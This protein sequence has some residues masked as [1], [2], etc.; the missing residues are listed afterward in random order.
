MKSQI[1]EVKW[2]SSKILNKTYNIDTPYWICYKAKQKTLKQK[3]RH[4][5]IKEGI[6]QS[7]FFIIL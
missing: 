7:L 2:T 5:I 4:I 3:I 1:Q 6:I